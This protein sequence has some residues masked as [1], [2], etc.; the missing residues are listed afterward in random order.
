MK[1]V[2]SFYG[3]GFSGSGL[4]E[5]MLKPVDQDI[6][7]WSKRWKL[8]VTKDNCPKCGVERIANIPFAEGTLR[9]FV[10]EDH[11]CGLNKTLVTYINTKED[12]KLLEIFD[13]ITEK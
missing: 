8:E 1:A 12:P 5:I 2:I 11:G 7:E 4:G 9:G 13:T 6:E 10:S 3:V